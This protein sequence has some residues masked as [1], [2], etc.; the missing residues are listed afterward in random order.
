MAVIVAST[1]AAFLGH[2]VTDAT[3]SNVA[4]SRIGTGIATAVGLI[5]VYVAR[6][7]PNPLRGAWL[8]V[9]G[10]CA[11]WGAGIASLP[12]TR[13][14]IEESSYL[15]VHIGW[16]GLVAGLAAAAILLAQPLRDPE[17]RRSLILDLVPTSIALTVVV[18]LAVIGSA[19]LDHEPSWPLLLAVVAHGGGALVLMLAAISSVLRPS[20]FVDP[21]PARLLY[22]G[23]AGL[24]IADLLWL[25]PWLADRAD[26]NLIA[27]PAFV[28]GFLAIGAAALLSRSTELR[29]EDAE[30]PPLPLLASEWLQ[31][32]PH[33][34][35]L[36]LLAF[37]IGQQVAG[38]LQPYGV[39]TALGG[40]I[41]VVIFVMMR[42]T[43]SLRH[44]RQLH[45]RIG[46]LNEQIDGLIE[47]VGR[48]PLTGLLNRRAVES[49]LEQEI[50]H[51]RACR[52]PVTVVLIDVDNFKTVNDTLGHQA[53]D[54][55][56]VAVGRVL[57][58]ACRGTDVAARYAGDEFLL[59]LPGTDETAAGEV[60]E[61]IV[62]E[63]RRLSDELSLGGIQVTISVGAAVT[64]RCHRSAA[65]LVAI[66]DAAMYDA[67]MEGKDRV[68]VIDADTLSV[69]GA[70]QPVIETPMP[71]YLPSQVVRPITERRGR[72][73]VVEKAS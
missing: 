65:Q 47:Q 60:C 34:S 2:V 32:L 3:F 7:R 45:G 69:P 6:S 16:V 10:G 38:N 19:G 26:T 67:K 4:A 62:G 22:A 37:T 56:L 64:H 42:Q 25:Q 24:A 12:A 28:S 33:Y 58:A 53:G 15:L 55:V 29:A 57:S 31:Q 54:R 23:M 27:R 8:A 52:H 13:G 5:A 63:I 51:G 49:R 61:R 14:R 20:R 66:A 59:V 44:A 18:W 68:L 17:A 43:L 40:C 30:E 35:L 71:I 41:A 73:L 1:I 48:D 72:R 21:V 9:A 36:L 39:E 70:S 50:A 46:Q 11:A